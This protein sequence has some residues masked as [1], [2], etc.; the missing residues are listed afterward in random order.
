MHDWSLVRL[1]DGKAGWVLTRALVMSIPDEVAQYAEGHRITSYFSLGEVRDGDQ[2]K[3]HWLWTTLSPNLQ[4]YQ[5]DSFRVF[6]YNTRRHRYETAY[7]ERNLKGYFPVAT[8]PVDVASGKQSIT[9]AGFSVILEDKQG[10]V[11]RCSYAFEGYRV[12]RVKKTPYQ[13]EKETVDLPDDPAG[14]SVE[15]Q[16]AWSKTWKERVLETFNGMRRKLSGR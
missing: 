9:V 8:H 7:I 5:Y 12:R 3:H 11:N 2:A 6:I 10:G 15:E 14:T 4:P 16:P 13:R 1:Q